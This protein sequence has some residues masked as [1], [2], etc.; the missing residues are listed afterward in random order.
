MAIPYRTKRVMK[1]I[2]IVLLV[3]LLVCSLV[4]VCWFLWLQRFV[5]YTREG[6]KFDMDYSPDFSDAQLAVPPEPAESVSVYYN[7]GDN[8]IKDNK[9]LVQFVGYY[10]DKNALEKDVQAVFAQIK[11]LPRDTAIMVDVKSPKGS[12]FYSSSV[13]T[14]RNP[15]VD[16]ATMDAIID[17]LNDPGIYAIARIPALRDYEYGLNHVLDGL[18][19]SG[20]Y[21]WADDDYCY[22]LDPTRQGTM[23][24]LLNI[25]NELKNLGFDEVVLDEFRFPNTDAILFS[26]DK[27]EALSQAANTLVNAAADTSFTLSFVGSS[28][29]ALPEG[30]CRLYMTGVAAADA[31]KVSQES[32]ITDANIRLVFL[33]EVHDTRF[34]EYCVLRPLDAAH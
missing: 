33:T 24:Y 20:G 25:V 31:A 18:P 19:V 21:L 1:R 6:A 7:E 13:S 26:G 5:V 29:F 8:T 2:G 30:R 28:G 4:M 14:K 11:A 32:G 10:A 16:T 17:Y 9:E 22:W 27:Q 12:F 15:D 34:D 3:L 23:T